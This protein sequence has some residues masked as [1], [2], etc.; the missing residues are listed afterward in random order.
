M[1]NPCYMLTGVRGTGKTVTLTEIEKEIAKEDN[2]IIIRLN[3]SRDM[4]SS[5]V[6]K[7]Y[8]SHEFIC[9]FVDANIN[10]SK[11]GIGVS[12]SSKSPVSDIESA[13]EIILKEIK[14]Q[15]YRLL[16]T[17]DEVSN[18]KSMREFASTYQIMIREELP[19]Y[20]IM[21]GL[22]STPIHLFLMTIEINHPMLLQT[23]YYQKTSY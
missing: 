12:I 22:Y 21:A 2:W 15:K 16:V 6:A 17:I 8:D 20:L 14:K 19:F 4:L 7:L 11:F 5:L 23:E 18:T 3:S 13:L 1:Q 10:L 9:K